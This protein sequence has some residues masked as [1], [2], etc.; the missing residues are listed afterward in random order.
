MFVLL[1]CRRSFIGVTPTS[2]FSSF[3]LPKTIVKTNNSTVKL[4]GYKHKKTKRDFIYLSLTKFIQSTS[5]V[6]S[7]YNIIFVG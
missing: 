4:Q 2:H 1:M 3:L 7:L 5:F 6:F